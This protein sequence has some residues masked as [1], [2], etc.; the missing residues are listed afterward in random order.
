MFN[1]VRSRGEPQYVVNDDPSMQAML[2]EIIQLGGR[3]ERPGEVNRYPYY[4]IH[5]PSR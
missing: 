3:L 4:L 5:W 1:F 2:D